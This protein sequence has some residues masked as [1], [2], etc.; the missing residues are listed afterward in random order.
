MFVLQISNFAIHHRDHYPLV[1]VETVDRLHLRLAQTGAYIQSSFLQFELNQISLISFK[2]SEFLPEIKKVLVLLY[3]RH[4]DGLR[5]DDDIPL[6]MPADE[7]L[8]SALAMR[9]GD[10]L[11]A[12][13]LQN[14]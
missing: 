1:P 2:S 9:F 10:L 12:G 7:N 4:N 13:I 5:N 8:C 3:L 6:E 14:L 11:E